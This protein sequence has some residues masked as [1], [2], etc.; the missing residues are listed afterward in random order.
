MDNTSNTCGYVIFI[1][2]PKVQMIYARDMKEVLEKIRALPK[3][4]RRDV[5]PLFNSPPTE[6]EDINCEDIG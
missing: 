3:D 1:S 6:H 4:T 5:Y 2:K